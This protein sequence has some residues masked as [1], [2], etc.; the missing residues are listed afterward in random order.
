MLREAYGVKRIIIRTGRTDLRLG[1]DG[2]A[3]FVKLN[4]GMN[5]M[6]DGTLFLFCG[7]RKDRIKG[8]Y[9][10]RDGYTLL[11]HR[12]TDGRYQ[13]PRNS[14]EARQLTREE[15]EKLM[16]GFTIEASIKCLRRSDK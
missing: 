10:D 15:Y 3:A 7:T 11:Y 6:E 1:V 2:L 12:L 13:W 8:L 9:Y 5:P 4:Y 16:D 14:E